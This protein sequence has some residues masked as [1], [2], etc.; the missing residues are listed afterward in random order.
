MSATLL[1]LGGN[2]FWDLD[3]LPSTRA[4]QPT[5]MRLDTQ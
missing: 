1:L 3:L 4:V 2:F 5:E